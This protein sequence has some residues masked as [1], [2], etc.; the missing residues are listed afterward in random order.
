MGMILDTAY[1]RMQLGYA[2]AK[3]GRATCTV[4]LRCSTPG[5]CVENRLH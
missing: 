1:S 5:T 4:E 3:K 2:L